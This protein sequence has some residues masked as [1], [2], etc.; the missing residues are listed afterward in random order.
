MKRWQGRW[1]LAVAALHTLV[2]VIEFSSV[3]TD[4]A[5]AGVINSIGT[6][7]LRGAVVWFLLFG[8]VLALVGIGL[9]RLERDGRS[10]GRALGAGLLGLALVG[11]L[12]MPVSG[13]W[14]ALPPALALLRSQG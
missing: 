14:L 4:L 7:P 9:D 2:G 11:G 6:D 3:L 1:L 8:W 5:H 10:G 12:L 13:F